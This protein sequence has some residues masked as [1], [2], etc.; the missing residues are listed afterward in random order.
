MSKDETTETTV[1]ALYNTDPQV[2]P[3]IAINI[4]ESIEKENNS[5]IITNKINIKYKIWL[6]SENISFKVI[7]CELDETRTNLGIKI[8]LK[9][10]SNRDVVIKSD[11]YQPLI[12]MYDNYKNYPYDITPIYKTNLNI[13]EKINYNLLHKNIFGIRLGLDIISVCLLGSSL[14]MIFLHTMNSK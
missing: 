11:K 10:N 3:N 8:S 1:V 6:M 7:L 5:N 12:T 9:N 4:D 14:C 13:F 2:N